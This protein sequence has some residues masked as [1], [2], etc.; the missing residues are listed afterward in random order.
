MGLLNGLAEDMEGRTFLH[1]NW[2]IY[3]VRSDLLDR[4]HLWYIHVPS[5]ANLEDLCA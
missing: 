4:R 1:F 5:I 3:E 2:L